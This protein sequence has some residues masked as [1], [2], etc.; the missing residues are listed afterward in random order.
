MGYK[1]LMVHLE[2]GQS[3]EKILA[4]AGN[5]AMRHKAHVIGIAS[6]QPIQ[7]AYNETYVSGEILVEDRKLIE[8]Q[9]K[10][11]E[12]QLLSALDG[13]AICMESRNTVTF[14]PLADYLAQQ[15]R[16]ADLIITGPDIRGSVFDHTR[17]V[18]IADLIMD[19]GRPV[20]IV[21]KQRS[22]LVLKQVIVAWKGTRECR[23]SIADALPMLKSAYAVTIVEIAPDEE[24]SRAKQHVADVISWL[25]RHGITAKGETLAATGDDSER[26]SDFARERRA[27]L[28]VAGAYGHSRLREWVLGGVTG[29][30]LINPDRCVLLSH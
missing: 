30:F 15:A 28:V 26:L 5:L 13:K 1:T 23:R 20:L 3:N 18:V 4:I 8:K 21:P 12:R 17:Q 10:D 7:L 6:C 16:A 9:M 14:G 25:G 24:I 2:L 27:D 29:D 11:A 19:A 22:E